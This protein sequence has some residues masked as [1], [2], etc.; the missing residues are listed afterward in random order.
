MDVL[1]APTHNLMNYEVDRVKENAMMEDFYKWRKIWYSTIVRC[2]ISM[3]SCEPYG[4]EKLKTHGLAIWVGERAE[5]GNLEASKLD[6]QE[7]ATRNKWKWN[8]NNWHEATSFKVFPSY[9]LK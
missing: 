7:R 9:I 4:L 5:Y 8:G 2:I 1:D 3:L 6:I